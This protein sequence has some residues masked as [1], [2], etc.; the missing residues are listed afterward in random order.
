LALNVSACNFYTKYVCNFDSS[1]CLFNIANIADI[2]ANYYVVNDV[3]SSTDKLSCVLL[4]HNL[5]ITHTLSQFNN[6]ISGPFRFLRASSKAHGI[7]FVDSVSYWPVTQRDF[8]HTWGCGGYRFWRAAGAGLAIDYSMFGCV[9]LDFGISNRFCN[10]LSDRFLQ[11]ADFIIAVS[12]DVLFKHFSLEYYSHNYYHL[13]FVES[14]LINEFST[15]FFACVSQ[16]LAD[17]NLS[18]TYLHSLADSNLS[19]SFLHFNPPPPWLYSAR[20]VFHV[21]SHYFGGHS[22][23]HAVSGDLA[24]CSQFCLLW[25]YIIPFL[26]HCHVFHILFNPY[27]QCCN[28]SN[29]GFPYPAVA[30]SGRYRQASRCIVRY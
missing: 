23:G 20:L 6:V 27:V 4:R 5:F 16:F 18:A 8:A 11:V 22:L 30:G 12:T 1:F 17:S 3:V 21:Y 7:D 9:D 24:I 13:F 28:F 10:I 26:S 19:A 2:V 29:L 25:H 14:V 15:V